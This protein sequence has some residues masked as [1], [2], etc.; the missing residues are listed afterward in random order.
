MWDA[1]K[2]FEIVWGSV[3]PLQRSIAD[4][5]L[6]LP[7]DTVIVAHPLVLPGA[8]M[9]RDRQPGLRLIGSYLAPANLRSC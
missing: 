7:G 4:L 9:A 2:G 6:G 3:A 1:R 5:L 8:A